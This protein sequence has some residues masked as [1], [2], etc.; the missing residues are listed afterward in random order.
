LYDKWVGENL[1]TVNEE[2]D[3]LGRSVVGVKAMENMHKEKDDL[4]RS[5]H[6]LKLHKEKDEFGRSALGVENAKRLHE[7]KDDLGRSVSAVKGAKTANAQKWKDPD[8]P[9]LGEHNSGNLVRMQKNRGY[10]HNRENRVK[11]G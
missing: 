10:P 9:E 11:V 8:H 5:L 4:G 3:D 7:E 2:K 1:K 6:T